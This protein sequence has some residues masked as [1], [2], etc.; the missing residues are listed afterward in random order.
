M[1]QVQPDVRAFTERLGIDERSLKGLL[2]LPLDLQVVVMDLVEKQQPNNASAVT[3][4]LVKK[5]RE[6]PS[7]LKLEYIRRHLDERCLQA[8]GQLAEPEQEVIALQVDAVKCR[9]L[10]AFVFAQIRHSQETMKRL[11]GAA[12]AQPPALMQARG[13]GDVPPPPP[14]SFQAPPP[15]AVQRP[16]VV[17]APQLPMVQQI[18]RHD[19]SRSPAAT[20]MDGHAAGAWQNE[21]SQALQAR[22]ME[23]RWALDANADKALSDFSQEDQL[24]IMG[25]VAKQNPRNPSAVA[26]SMVK[27]MRERPDEARFEYFR[28]VLDA[29]A[30]AALE[31]MP[32]HEMASI[33]SRV[34]ISTCRNISA[35]IWSMIKPRLTPST[36][37]GAGTVTPVQVPPPPRAVVPPPMATPRQPVVESAVAG[38]NAVDPVAMSGL[39]LD[40]R[41]LA[42]LHQLSMN[43]QLA[44]LSDIDPNTCRNPSAYVWSKIQIFKKTAQG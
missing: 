2:E 14:P 15:H 38:G 1:T 39:H 42:A 35:F 36:P 22:A 26:W 41:C 18:I 3:W 31:S 4:S 16:V 5:I 8:L 27:L 20:A 6:R 25:L 19:R 9:N 40:E 44:V 23:L 33:F 43:E 10:S 13:G 32:P 21:D 28:A 37:S 7:G 24:I 17:P 11:S 30:L 12:F 29:E 34:P